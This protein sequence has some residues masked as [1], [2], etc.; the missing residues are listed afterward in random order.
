MGAGAGAGV[1]SSRFS[2]ASKTP[3]RD[4][5]PDNDLAMPDTLDLRSPVSFSTFATADVIVAIALTTFA[6]DMM[7]HVLFMAARNLEVE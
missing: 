1:S 5:M 3:K 2:S 6:A 4:S 7:N